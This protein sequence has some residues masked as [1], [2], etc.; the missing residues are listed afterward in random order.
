MVMDMVH[1]VHQ[2]VLP[3]LLLGGMLPLLLLGV[4]LPLGHLH[5]HLHPHL[6]L[7]NL[8]VDMVDLT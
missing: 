3:L 2:G 1:L 6:R 8:Q 7:V 5:P 4:I